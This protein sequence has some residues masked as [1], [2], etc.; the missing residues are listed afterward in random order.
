MLKVV[1][2]ILGRNINDHIPPIF[3]HNPLAV[4]VGILCSEIVHKNK[5]YYQ[6]LK[7]KINSIPTIHQQGVGVVGLCTGCTKHR[8]EGRAGPCL[9]GISLQ[10]PSGVTS[11]NITDATPFKILFKCLVHLIHCEAYNLSLC[12]LHRQ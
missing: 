10:I 2:A 11:P 3:P 12:P 1:S 8:R 5:W 6:P 7:T 4:S 9:F